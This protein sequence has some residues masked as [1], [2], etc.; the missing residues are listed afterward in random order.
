MNQQLGVH[1][2]IFFKVMPYDGQ[3]LGIGYG[4]VNDGEQIMFFLYHMNS[5]LIQW[6]TVD[7]KTK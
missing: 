2:C 4:S 6:I 1:Y 3:Q 7:T 5:V